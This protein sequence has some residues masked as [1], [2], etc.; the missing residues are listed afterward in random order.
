[1]SK[2]LLVIET[3]ECC[4]KCM[5][6]I[7]GFC[8]AVLEPNECVEGGEMW[9]ETPKACKPDWCPLHPIPEKKDEYNSDTDVCYYRRQGWNSCVDEILEGSE[10]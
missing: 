2:S 10:S 1:M 7:D 3:P 4:E 5:I 9:K 8:L 6:N